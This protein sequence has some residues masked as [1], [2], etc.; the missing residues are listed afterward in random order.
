MPRARKCHQRRRRL[1][2]AAL[3]AASSAPSPPLL[4]LPRHQA[5]N[6]WRLYNTQRPDI[7]EQT[8]EL[9]GL[10]GRRGLGLALEGGDAGGSVV[11]ASRAAAAFAFGTP[12]GWEQFSLLFLTADGDVFSLCPL[13][14][15]G[16]HLPAGALDELAA[17][18]EVAAEEMGGEAAESAAATTQAW[19]QQAFR[20][21]AAPVVAAAATTSP[22]FAAGM[23]KSVP[24]ALDEHVPALAG[25]LHVATTTGEQFSLTELSTAGRDVAQALAVAR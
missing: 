8:Y 15:F 2:C 5:D 24:H 1:P 20:P 3:P 16:C 7:A 12:S 14:P 10:R 11:E 6:T 9:T 18:A 19:L 25:P 21:A 13:V 22:V 4:P 23:V 17:A